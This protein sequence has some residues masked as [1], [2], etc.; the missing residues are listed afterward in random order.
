[1]VSGRCPLLPARAEP[2]GSL[3]F[4]YLSIHFGF[5]SYHDQRERGCCA[6]QPLDDDGAGTI[7]GAAPIKL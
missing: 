2:T 7:T 3:R 5:G 6:Q 1:M 4:P